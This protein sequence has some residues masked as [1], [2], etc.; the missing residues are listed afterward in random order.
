[1]CQMVGVKPPGVSGWLDGNVATAPDDLGNDEIVPR[2]VP[3]EDH[4]F[5]SF[6]RQIEEH[7]DAD[8]NIDS[9]WLAQQKMDLLKFVAESGFTGTALTHPLPLKDIPDSVTIST[10]AASSSNLSASSSTADYF[11]RLTSLRHHDR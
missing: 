11:L 4:S 6:L 9:E 5:D 1:M 10:E 7:E 3:N 8:G 2:E